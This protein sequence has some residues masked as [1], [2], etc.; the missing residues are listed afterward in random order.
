MINVLM[1]IVLI[2]LIVLIFRLPLDSSRQKGLMAVQ[3]IGSIALRII[4][5]IS[6]ISFLYLNSSKSV[7]SLDFFKPEMDSM[8]LVEGLLAFP[9]GEKGELSVPV[10]AVLTNIA[11]REFF[12]FF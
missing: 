3:F 10:W 8:P 12:N 6:I 11:M 4:S 9:S 5:Y 7:F 1:F 2:V